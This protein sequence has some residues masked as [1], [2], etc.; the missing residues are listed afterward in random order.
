[1]KRSEFDALVSGVPP[2]ERER[3]RRA[4][5]ALL[6]V[7]PPPGLPEGLARA[8]GG[9]L[10]RFSRRRA[11]AI[12]LAATLAA[13]AFAGGYLVGS[14]G[15]DLAP[16]FSLDLRGTEAAPAAEAELVVFEQDE[17][18]NWPMEMTV[19]GLPDGR[20][21]L[22]LTRNGLP[23]ASCGFFQVRGRTVTYLNAP[24]RL[25]LYDGWAITRPGAVR[26]L[27]RTNEI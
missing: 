17:A 6:A 1:M 26:I 7:G 20:Y 16:D 15:P 2:E 27:L 3:L 24:Y 10:A 23:A 19:S 8:P 13:A 25:K 5:E 12:A 11:L 14:G 4:H 9:R 21:E 22:V 18:G